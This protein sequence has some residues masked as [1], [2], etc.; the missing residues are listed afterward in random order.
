MNDLRRV[1]IIVEKRVTAE[2]FIFFLVV[3]FFLWQSDLSFAEIK[4]RPTIIKFRPNLANIH[5][6]F[7]KSAEFD[8]TIYVFSNIQFEH[9]PLLSYFAE[10][11]VIWQQWTKTQRNSFFVLCVLLRISHAPHYKIFIS[12]N[13]E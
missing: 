2:K 8:S 9:W 1:L 7:T 3:K 10:K 4:I 5:V 6:N 13:S 12:Y 11:S